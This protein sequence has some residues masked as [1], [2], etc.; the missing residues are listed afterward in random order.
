VGSWPLLGSHRCGFTVLR[1]I[2]VGRRANERPFVT[3]DGLWPPILGVTR[4]SMSWPHGLVG[5]VLWVAG[6]EVHDLAVSVAPCLFVLCS[7]LCG[8]C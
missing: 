3:L 7:C 4:V 6:R 2:D 5:F 1:V 8:V